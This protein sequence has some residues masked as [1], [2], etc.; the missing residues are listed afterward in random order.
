MSGKIILGTAN[1]TNPYGILSKGCALGENDVLSIISYAFE[2]GVSTLDTA[3]GYGDLTK[4]V[5]KDLLSQFNLITK[6][7][8]L[9]S[10]DV[11][12]EKL[13]PY[14][15]LNLYGLL[16]HD[17]GNLSKVA[18]EVLSEKLTAVQK[19]YDIEKIGVSAYGL[20]DVDNFRKI[21]EPQ[22]IQIPLNPFNQIF[23]TEDFM[24]YV[25]DNDIEVHA[26]SLF[27]QGIL[28]AK[29]LPEKLAELY[30]QWKHVKDALAPC[31]S[32]LAGLI[33]WAFHQDWISHWV[34]GVSSIH[35]LKDILKASSTW[36]T[37]NILPQFQPSQHPLIDP[38]NW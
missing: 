3:L 11:L 7:S 14:K 27:L 8:V 33:S 17:P 15:C 36:G 38:R 13:Q 5:S 9:D 26:R 23:K 20:E 31:S 28:L 6:V 34:L 1:F 19:A 32:D 10:Q 25:K 21:Q 18:P 30:E 35:D 12:L 29:E 4:T 24:R 22:I 2:H 16:I 37:E